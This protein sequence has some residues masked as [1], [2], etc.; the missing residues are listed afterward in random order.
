M[1]SVAHSEFVFAGASDFSKRSETK[2]QAGV[3]IG[4]FIAD[5]TRLNKCKPI[6]VTSAGHPRRTRMRLQGA[7]LHREE[8]P[9]YKLVYKLG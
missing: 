1:F 9:R 7:V 5:T 8:P 3:K 6:A 4:F 2:L